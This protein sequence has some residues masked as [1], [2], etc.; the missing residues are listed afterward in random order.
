[1][2]ALPVYLKL[3]GT[4][5]K[6]K[7]IVILSSNFTECHFV[8]PFIHLYVIYVICSDVGQ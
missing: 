5:C 6:L 4:N 1:M 7:F 3:S 8:G 2:I